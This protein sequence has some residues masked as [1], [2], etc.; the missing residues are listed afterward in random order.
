VNWTEIYRDAVAGTPVV[1]ED[2]EWPQPLPP[3]EGA[4]SCRPIPCPGSY[5]PYHDDDC[6]LSWS[7]E[8]PVTEECGCEPRA[9]AVRDA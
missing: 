1:R 4:K 8:G 5:F 6:E 9:R 3:L 2:V 7:E